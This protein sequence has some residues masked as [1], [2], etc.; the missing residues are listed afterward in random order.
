[1][2]AS[3]VNQA[4][5]QAK[6]EKVHPGNAVN[7]AGAETRTFADGFDIAQRREKGGVTERRSSG[8]TLFKIRGK[9]GM[10][11]GHNVGHT[12]F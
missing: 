2:G 11:E 5:Q 7:R 4:A 3:H 10:T 12:F 9:G 1:M 8:H 6:I